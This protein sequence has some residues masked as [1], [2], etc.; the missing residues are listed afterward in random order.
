MTI[1]NE[2]R[3]KIDQEVDRTAMARMLNLTEVLE[4]IIDRLDESPLAKKQFVGE[5][6]QTIVHLFAEFRD[7]VDA[8][9]EEVLGK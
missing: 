1:G 7:E 9:H 6:E 3:D 5:R 2:T 4:L 8:P